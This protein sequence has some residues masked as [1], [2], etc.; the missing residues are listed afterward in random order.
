MAPRVKP[1]MSLFVARLFVL[2]ALNATESGC[3]TPPPGMPVPPPPVQL[4]A[5]FQLAVAAPVQEK[6]SAV[7]TGLEIRITTAAATS[8][9]LV[10][11]LETG[12]PRRSMMNLRGER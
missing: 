5:L 12:R 9:H 11:C 3:V 6:V 10:S 7:A 8:A 1:A 4:P 2:P